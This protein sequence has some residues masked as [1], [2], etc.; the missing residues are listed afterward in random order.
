MYFYAEDPL[1]EKPQWLIN[2]QQRLINKQSSE[3]FSNYKDLIENLND[4]HDIYEN[5]E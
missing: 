2:K 1:E 3:G 4:M 5:I